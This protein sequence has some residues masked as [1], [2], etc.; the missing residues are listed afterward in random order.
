MQKICEQCSKSFWA[1][2]SYNIYCSQRCSGLARIGNTW[3]FQKGYKPWNKGKP[4][5]NVGERNGLW[6]GNSVSYRGIHGWV[7]LHKGKA[8]QCQ[9]CKKI[10][11]PRQIHWANID[12][13]YHRNLDDYIQLCCSCHYRHD[14]TNG[15]R[16]KIFRKKSREHQQGASTP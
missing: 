4:G 8:K 5:V 1:I 14:V 15:L 16:P 3:G 11:S 10:G 7:W 6:K 9:K 2:H 13:K 12:H